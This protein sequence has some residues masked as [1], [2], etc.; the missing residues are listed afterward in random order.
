VKKLYYKFEDRTFLD[1]QKLS[2]SDLTIDD[3][4]IPCTPQSSPWWSNLSH[5]IDKEMKSWSEYYSTIKKMAFDGKISRQEAEQKCMH[6]PKTMKSC[7]GIMALFRTAYIVRCPCDIHATA[8]IR[9]KDVICNTPVPGVIDI[10]MHDPM[11]LRSNPNLFEGKFSIKFDMPVLLGTKERLPYAF[12]NP[13]YHT[14]SV[15]DVIPGVIDE[16]Y[17]GGMGLIVNTLVDSNHP[18]VHI[19][20]N[21]YWSFT[22]KK[23]QPIAYIWYPERTKLV[24]GKV[25][26]PYR[27]KL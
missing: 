17:S 14:K 19:D 18:D 10:K 27:Q 2:N 1:S 13:S 20:E 23:H 26:T 24:Q 11:Q 12:L 25:T 4:L 9:D 6:I 5:Y 8:S 7:P 16:K 3:Y 21:G 15:F 22:M